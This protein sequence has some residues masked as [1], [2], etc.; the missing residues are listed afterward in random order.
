MDGSKL[1][2]SSLGNGPDTLGLTIAP[3][4]DDELSAGEE[5]HANLLVPKRSN[6]ICGVFLQTLVIMAPIDDCI[7]RDLGI[8]EL[9]NYDEPEDVSHL[10][11]LM[12]NCFFNVKSIPSQKMWAYIARPEVSKENAIESFKALCQVLN[13]VPP[14]HKNHFPKHHVSGKLKRVRFFLRS[15]ATSPL[16]HH[17]QF[18]LSTVWTATKALSTTPSGLVAWQ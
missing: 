7:E 18:S 4:G 6:N 17:A 10:L 3:A 1:S 13:V 11:S 15:S 9:F 8:F 12:I 14:A 2:A 5:G 16:L